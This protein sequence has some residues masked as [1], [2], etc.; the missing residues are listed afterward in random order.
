MLGWKQMMRRAACGL[1]AAIL[2]LG[3]GGETQAVPVVGSFSGFASSIPGF[4]QF[5]TPPLS[6]A[7]CCASFTGRFTYDTEP[8]VVAR[9]NPAQG[10]YVFT[11][12]AFL[13]FTIGLFDGTSTMYSTSAAPGAPITVM[14]SGG[15]LV[16]G[17]PSIVVGGVF[18]IR[19]TL[20]DPTNPTAHIMPWIHFTDTGGGPLTSG[21]LPTTSFNPRGF[22][23]PLADLVL[24]GTFGPAF[25]PALVDALTITTVP[26]PSGIG[27]LSLA[28]IAL[29]FARIRK[30]G[31]MS[32]AS[33][34]S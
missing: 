27:M 29:G 3:T 6:N 5:L 32:R 20:A 23:D 18:S 4:G 28:L 30:P 22:S 2:V 8:A 11:Q 7:N 17:N 25:V 16:P 21:A 12:D 10:T 9:P 33:R 26:E 15:E 13:S 34:L 1:A 31:R 24:E 19:G 14:A